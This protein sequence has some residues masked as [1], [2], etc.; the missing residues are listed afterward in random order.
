VKGGLLPAASVYNHVVELVD[1]FPTLVSL[2][3][4]RAPPT[5]YGLEGDDLVPGII[6]GGDSKRVQA[7]F[8]QITRCMNC[9]AAYAIV[10]DER[11]GCDADGADAGKFYVPCSQTN[12]SQFDLMG[13]SIRTT[14]W[15]CV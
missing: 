12:R 8:S 15:R 9:D 5:D 3:N 14:D 6:S 7:A 2:A 10:A 4:L 11:A 13:M 1:L